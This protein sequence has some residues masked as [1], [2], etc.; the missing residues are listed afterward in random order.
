MIKLKFLITMMFL[1]SLNFNVFAKRKPKEYNA[2]VYTIDHARYKGFLQQATQKGVTI[3][4]MGVPKFISADVISRIKVKRTHAL[5]QSVLI[6]SVFG[7]VGGTA[8]YL[9]EQD[10]KAVNVSAIPVIVMGS[11]IVAGGIGG[12]INTITSVK[13][14]KNLAEGGAYRKIQADLAKYSDPTFSNK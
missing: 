3:D 14:Y 9:Y 13:N 2:I 4:Y 10:K 8:L 5:S 1:T 6:S 11:T 7:L 12:L